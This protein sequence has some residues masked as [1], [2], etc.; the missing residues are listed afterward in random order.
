MFKT[1]IIVVA[2]LFAIFL[3]AN[4]LGITGNVVRHMP[5]EPVCEEPYIRHAKSC[6]LDQN[7]NNICDNDEQEED[8]VEETNNNPVGCLTD[9][10]CASGTTCYKGECIRLNSPSCT[11]T[12]GIS[13]EDFLVDRGAIALNLRNGMG[14][15][16]KDVT[17]E[18]TNFNGGTSICQL[19]CISGCDGDNM[20]H[21]E[22]T[23]WKSTNCD[24]VISG[25]VFGADIIFNYLGA[26]GL[27]HSKTGSLI[28]S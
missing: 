6:C 18:I 26:S 1:I 19:S 16:L 3:L 17:V 5:E 9:R 8:I 21:G 27:T 24:F 28:I 4:S 15:E 7:S 10:S 14:D 2:I 25:R 13:C 22:L 11:I 20:P 23:T 12:P